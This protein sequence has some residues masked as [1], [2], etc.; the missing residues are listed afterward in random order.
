[1]AGLGNCPCLAAA[2]TVRADRQWQ[3]VP[4]TAAALAVTAP[5]ASGLYT[6]CWWRVTI[7][8]RAS[9]SGG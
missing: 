1:M 8:G 2:V 3:Y 7:H 4:V 6:G 9:G 5:G